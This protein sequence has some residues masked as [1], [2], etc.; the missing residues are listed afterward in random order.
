MTLGDATFEARLWRVWWAAL[1]LLIGV[2]VLLAAVAAVLV[3]LK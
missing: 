1:A 2:S 3:V